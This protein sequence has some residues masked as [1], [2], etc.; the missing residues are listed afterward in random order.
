MGTGHKVVLSLQVTILA[1]YT[2]EYT[3]LSNKS[4]CENFQCVIFLISLQNN[5]A[6]RHNQTLPRATR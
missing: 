5:W 1:I 6:H 2:S 3:K 4:F